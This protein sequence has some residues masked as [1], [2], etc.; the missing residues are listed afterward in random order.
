MTAVV[1]EQQQWTTQLVV[2]GV[3][4]WFVVV[5]GNVEFSQFVAERTVP[6][7]WYVIFVMIGRCPLSRSE[8]HTRIDVIISL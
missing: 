7:A 5:M 2:C 3:C 8:A 4:A 1:L 6:F